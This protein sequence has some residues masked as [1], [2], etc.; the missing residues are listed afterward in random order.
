MDLLVTKDVPQDGGGITAVANRKVNTKVLVE[1]G[2]TLVI[3]GIYS[4]DITESASGFP[5]LK[6]IPIIGVLFGSKGKNI[7]RTERFSVVTPRVLN[8][9]KAGLET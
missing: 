6:D 2:S 7:S 8:V 4:S 1:S 3:G 5:V 9:E